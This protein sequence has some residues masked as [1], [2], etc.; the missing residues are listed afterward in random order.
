MSG[1]RGRTLAGLAD[2]ALVAV[3]TAGTGLLGTAVLAPREAGVMLYTI[4]ILVFVQGLGRAFV[5]DVML[6]HVP[7]YAAGPARRGQFANAH[8]TSGTLAAAAAVVLL[9]VWALGPRR[10]VG[11]LVWGVPFVPSILLQDLAR[12][13]YQTEGRQPRALVIDACWVVV[14]GACLAVLLGTGHA[15]GGP[16][17]ACWGIGATAGAALFYART[18]I[19]PLAGRPARWLSDTRRL[20]GWFTATGV[21]AQLTTLLIASLVQGILTQA[22]YSGLRLVQTVVL[23]PAQSFTMAL[24]GL[25]V[26]RA[27]ALAGAG[28]VAGLRRQTR[29]VLAVNAAIGAC[30][31][32][33]AVPL[34]HPV[35]D[36]YHGGAYA[37]VAAIA[38]PV[39]VQAGVYLLQ[40][41]FTVAIRGMHRARLLFAQY[42]IF[43]VTTLGGLVLGAVQG[44]LVGAAWGLMAGAGVGTLVQAGMYL[45]ASR[46]MARAR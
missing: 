10:Y 19:N 17:V 38:L 13:T 14:Q 35:L 25:L 29:T 44:Q 1:L 34:A 20:L 46:A 2:Q 36:W 39:S 42:A 27:S 15:A 6:A 3:T 5:G 37:A 32:A 8:A 41:P 9:L 11:D 12:Y 22:A 30:I 4:A 31:V 23:Q 16:I 26:P 43:A 45:A 33:V 24:N 28:D 7:R 18:R 40:I 21:L